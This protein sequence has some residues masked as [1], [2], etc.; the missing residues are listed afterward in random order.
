MIRITKSAANNVVVTT[1]EKGTA[2]HYLFEFQ[3]LTTLAKKY[4]ISEDTSAFQDRYNAFTITDTASPTA[5]DSEVN[6]DERENRYVI[7]A[8]TDASNLDPDGLTVLET[9]MCEVTGTTTNP[10]EYSN[11]PTYSVYNG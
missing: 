10:T 9:G 8:N 3:N 1:T 11:N 4:C 5:T 6:L 7:Y 2:S